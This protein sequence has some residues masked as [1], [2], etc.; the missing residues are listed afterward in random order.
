V[1]RRP[2]NLLSTLSLLLCAAITLLWVRSYFVGDAFDWAT[3]TG[4]AGVDSCRGSLS[5]G[6]VYVPPADLAN[7]E[8]RTLYTSKPASEAAGDRIM[9]A[10]SFAGFALV[11]FDFRGMRF[12]ELR[13]PFWLVVLVTGTAPA[14]HLWRKRRARMAAGRCVSCGYN[15]TGNVSGVCPECGSP[16]R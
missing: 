12:R 13:V 11:R 15:L 1:K 3:R 2:L 9:P 4:R 10:W 5:M 14:V 7:I 6:W 16:V 8:R